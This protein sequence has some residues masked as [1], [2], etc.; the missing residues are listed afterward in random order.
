MKRKDNSV[1]VPLLLAIL[2][3]VITALSLTSKEMFFG[4]RN[5]PGDSSGNIVSWRIKSLGGP[6]PYIVQFVKIP[7]NS[8]MDSSYGLL[9]V[10]VTCK[11]LDIEENFDYKDFD[12]FTIDVPAG[13]TRVNVV[14]SVEGYVEQ[15]IST[16]EDHEPLPLPNLARR[17]KNI[18]LR[19]IS[20]S[21]IINTQGSADEPI[22]F[23]LDNLETTYGIANGR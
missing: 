18:M 14:Y 11:S 23:S 19:E 3:I 6:G 8:V 1:I 2:V 7:D 4:S 20:T 17:L 22:V 12:M 21:Y 13:L 15:F 10:W 16:Q 5:I 9:S